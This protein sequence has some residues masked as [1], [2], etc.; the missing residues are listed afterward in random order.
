MPEY[1]L[2]VNN[3]SKSF[4]GL[5]GAKQLILEEINFKIK[6]ISKDGNI[7]SILSPTN[8]SKTELFKIIS[9]IEKPSGG[10]IILLG[11]K[12]E[13]PIGEIVLIPEKP[14]SFPWM[15]VKQ[16][17]EFALGLHNK[18]RI[19]QE[20]I[21]EIISLVGLTG[22]EDHF[23]NDKSLGF[24]FRISFA[25][26]LAV[27]PKIILMDEPL[28]N[29]HGETKKEIITLICSLTKQLNLT[30]LISTANV[31]EA[32]S[33]SNKIILMNSH[34]GKTIGEFEIDKTQN[35]Q[36][37]TDYFISVKHSIEKSFK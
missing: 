5:A 35:L 1:L 36:E 18:D 12:F 23:P 27:N 8:S 9:A 2:E 19:K 26:A 11:K 17:I 37:H 13:K 30:I 28:K 10:E 24:R 16:N 25:R 34:P 6:S 20:K 31:N 33:I 22:Y 32:I 3:I 14:S 29:L 15:N 21:N 7:I 4:H